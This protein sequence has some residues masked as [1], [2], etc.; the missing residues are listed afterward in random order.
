M[1]S[2]FYENY[3]PTGPTEVASIRGLQAEML[4]ETPLRWQVLVIQPVK[5]ADSFNG[6]PELTIQGAQAGK[7][8]RMNLPDGPKLLL[9]KQYRRMEGVLDVPAR[10]VVKTVTAKIMDGATIRSVHTFTL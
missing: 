10:T 8:W 2:V 1:I 3:L 7:P 9:F 4:P 5:G 6:K